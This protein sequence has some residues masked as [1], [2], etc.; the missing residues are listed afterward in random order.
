MQVFNITDYGAVSSDQ[1]QTEKIQAA[2]DACFLAGGGEVV[3]PA[4]VYRTG[5]VRVRSNVTIH[6]L[7]GAF[8]EGSSDPEDYCGYLNDTVEPL[9][10][11]PITDIR[12]TRSAQWY[13]RW[14][15][16]LFKAVHAENIA[17]IGDPGSIIDGCNCYDPQ[18]EENYRG[19]HPISFWYCRGVELRGYAIKN[20]ANWAHAI[21]N[22]ENITMTNVSVYGGHDGFDARTCDHVL[23]EDC[24]FYT[25]DD[26]IAGFD[27]YDV[28][29]RRCLFNT[30]CAPLRLGATKMLVEDCRAFGP[31][32][33]G[34]RGT[35]DMESRKRSLIA[36]ATSRYTMGD[37]FLYYC[38]FRAEIRYTPGDIIIRNC[39]FENL[40]RLFCLPFNY[41]TRWCVNRSLSFIRFENCAVSGVRRPIFIMGDEYEPLTLELENVTI[42]PDEENKTLPVLVAEHFERISFKNVTCAGFTDP[43]ILIRTPGK[44]ST[45]GGT[46]LPVQH[47]GT[48]NKF[49]QQ[50]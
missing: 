5:C 11:V 10:I 13:S 26:C 35:M 49:Y 20:S 9:T 15:N 1:L 32:Q 27:D 19:P 7:S 45:E 30:A 47:L 48:I 43:K 17:I 34:F 38:D 12:N 50:Y 23:I 28:T 36:D 33:F 46:P 18:G 42:S 44:V 22:S 4:G 2:I 6:L 8:I 25:G 31:A 21:F 3:I 37:G 40:R 39:T 24:K 41:E 14:S 29:I 16:G